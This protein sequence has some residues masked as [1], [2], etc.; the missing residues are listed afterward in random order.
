MVE[1]F[2]PVLQ[3]YETPPL[4]VNETFAPEHTVGEVTTTEGIGLMVATAAVPAGDQH[5]AEVCDHAL[6]VVV[7]VKLGVVKLLPVPTAVAFV[8]SYHTIVAPDGGVAVNVTEPD[9]HL[10]APLAVG[11]AGSALIVATT[12][13]FADQHPVDVFCAYTLYVALDDKLGVV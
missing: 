5:P 8:A 7:V 6:Y 10:L 11:A 13:V 12:S 2:S 3:A 4:A 1:L 9:P